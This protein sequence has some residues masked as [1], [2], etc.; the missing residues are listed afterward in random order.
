MNATQIKDEA[1]RLERLERTLLHVNG[2]LKNDKGYIYHNQAEIG[3]SFGNDRYSS[4][5]ATIKLDIDEMVFTEAMAT[6]R[7]MLENLIA[8]CKKRLKGLIK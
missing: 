1:E 7:E 4:H 8:S 3:V 2:Y 5:V 6:K